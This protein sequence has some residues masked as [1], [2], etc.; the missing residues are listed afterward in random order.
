MPSGGVGGFGVWSV[1]KEEWMDETFRGRERVKE[2]EREWVQEV[3]CEMC[4]CVFLGGGAVVG[5]PPCL[6]PHATDSDPVNPSDLDA[7][8]AMRLA[9]AA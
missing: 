6:S 9:G 3:L 4:T 7:C 5:K 8:C 2:G 1:Y